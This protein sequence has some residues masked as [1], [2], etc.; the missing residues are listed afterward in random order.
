MKKE[1]DRANNSGQV[2]S[3]V[4]AIDLGSNTCR[5]LIA[6]P[7]ENGYKVVDSFSR[8]IRLGAGLQSTGI[9]SEAAISRSID[10]LKICAEKLKKFHIT[11]IRAV[12]TEACRKAQN[13]DIFLE[14]VLDE[15]GI[16]LEIISEFEEARLSLKG[17]SGLINRDYGYVLGFDIG[18]CSTE[19]MWAQNTSSGNPQVID[20][21]S[22]P[23]GIVSLMDSCA[24]DALAFYDEIR[25][26]VWNGL[27]Q[28]R[29]H[30]LI[31][32]EVRNKNV[33]TIGS[34]GTTTTIAALH[35]KLPRYDR[36]Q[37]DGTTL[38]VSSLHHIAHNL[39]NM[40]IRERFIN[41]NIGPGRSEAVIAGLAI[42]QG[43]CD[44]W[45]INE[46]TV[47]D[48]GVRDGILSDMLIDIM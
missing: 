17:C 5:L 9:L 22:I 44:T 3:Y 10:I 14:R 4:A 30:S 41:T 47:A 34:S 31:E 19:V 39:K 36:N 2:A 23:Y 21:I 48:R 25:N 11:K 6:K 28:I 37:V 33:Q 13:K 26:K 43:I 32:D 20:W 40:S 24:G 8:V 45:S 18:G 27:H 35:L 29:D 12:A 15:T 16:Q 1:S 7:Y 46:I 42:L 38:P